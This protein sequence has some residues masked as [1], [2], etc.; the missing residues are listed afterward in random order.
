[1]PHDTT[2]LIAVPSVI[3]GGIALA[4]YYWS[5]LS[6]SKRVDPSAYPRQKDR[7]PLYDQILERKSRTR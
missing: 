4:G 5:L 6:K 7:Q 3:I 1:M 2:T